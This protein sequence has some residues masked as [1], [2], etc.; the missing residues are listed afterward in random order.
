MG[1]I[2]DDLDPSSLFSA[3][4]RVVD[5]YRG[6]LDP[7]MVKAL[8]CTKDSVAAARKGDDSV[9]FFMCLFKNAASKK[10]LVSF[11]C[12]YF[13]FQILKLLVQLWVFLRWMLYLQPWLKNSNLRH[14]TKPDFQS[15]GF[16]IFSC[17]LLHG[18]TYIEITCNVQ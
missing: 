9:M 13:C 6:Q 17:Q 3:A 7:E 4:G 5:P 14:A 15:M 10:A 12:S 1:N 8:I 18:K 2:D 16:F 11:L